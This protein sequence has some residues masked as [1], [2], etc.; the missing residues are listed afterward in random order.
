VL[1]QTGYRSEHPSG[2]LSVQ[3]WLTQPLNAI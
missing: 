3:S 1:A 2:K